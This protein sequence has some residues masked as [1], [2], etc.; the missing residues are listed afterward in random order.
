MR[1][2][3]V[4]PGRA[5]TA[6]LEEVAEPSLE[7]GPLLIEALALGVCGTDLE[8]VEGRYGSAPPGRE[9]LILGHETIGRVLEAPRGG[10]LAP[11]DLIVGIVRRP[12]PV[13]CPC[14]AVGE[15]DMCRNGRYTERGIK[16]RD[17]YCSERY[18]IDPTFAVKVDP[19][20][21]R[22]GVLLEPASV[23][24][25][26]WE[27]IE[28]IGLRAHWE[29]RRVLVTGAGPIGMLAALMGVQRG[30]EVHLLDR[31]AEGSKPALARELGAIYHVGESFECGA[32]SGMDVVIECTGIGEVVLDAIRCG[33]PG[34]IVCLTGMSSG[35]RELALD[36]A[37]LN[38]SMVLENDVIF[39]SVNSN[40]RHYEAGADALLRADAGWLGRLISRRV[41]LARWAEAL[42]RRPDDIKTVIDL[43]AEGPTEPGSA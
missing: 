39:G 11:G 24:A 4:V 12:D 29:P 9:R 6:R 28:R 30:L 10:D 21:G 32:D 41:P 2:L 33:A 43:V 35:H 7:D 20:L 31:V 40:R 13:P 26:A 5:G 8:I 17:G 23:L 3:T 19:K 42:D 18:R 27:H 36:I 22:L 38:R 15:W 37:G 25:K 1:A 14:C 16:E 34:G